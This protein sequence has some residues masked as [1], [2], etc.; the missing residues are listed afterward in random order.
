MNDVTISLKRP[1]E[2]HGQK[3]NQ[4]VL[5][6]PTGKEIITCGYPFAIS[7][8][9]AVPVAAVV[10]KYISQC[11]GIPPHSV[12]QLCPADFQACVAAVLGFFG[13]PAAG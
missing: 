9:G 11:G 4:I 13:D 6:E 2:A 12:Q 8:G 1:I 3:V 5:K 7:D 10:A